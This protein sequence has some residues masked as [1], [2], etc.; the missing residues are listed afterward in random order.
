MEMRARILSVLRKLRHDN[1]ELKQRVYDL[2]GRVHLLEA[3]RTLAYTPTS[4]GRLSHEH[5][6]CPACRGTDTDPPDAR[7]ER[8]CRDCGHCWV[9]GSR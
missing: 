5:A 8:Y 1:L 2:E 9:Y 7:G 3:D 6:V 4:N